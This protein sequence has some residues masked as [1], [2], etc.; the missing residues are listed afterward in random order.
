MFSN[1]IGTQ[2]FKRF[3]VRSVQVGSRE[4]FGIAARV[5]VALITRGRGDQQHGR[6]SIDDYDPF[7]VNRGLASVSQYARA[8]LKL[9]RLALE[10]HLR[11]LEVAPGPSYFASGIHAYSSCCAA[12]LLISSAFLTVPGPVGS[13][14]KK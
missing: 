14:S 4:R 13:D 3:C 12:G 2:S 6:V 10:S 5:F 8:G 7:L 1:V 11:R 9:C